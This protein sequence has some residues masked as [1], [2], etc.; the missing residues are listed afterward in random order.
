MKDPA[1]LR[2]CSFINVQILLDLS[3]NSSVLYHILKLFLSQNM[4]V[5]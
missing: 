4:S 3:I 5:S 2:C 1:H